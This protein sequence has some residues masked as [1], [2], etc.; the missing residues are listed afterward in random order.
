MDKEIKIQWEIPKSWIDVKLEDISF[1]IQGQSPPSS[2]YNSERIGLPFF[3][4]KA[5]FTDLHPKVKVWCKEPTKIA[6]PNDILLSVRA[7]VGTTNIANLK[8]GIGRGLSAIRYQYAHKFVFYYLRLIERELDK[9]GT[10]TTFK[11]IS[12]DVVRNTH[13]PLPPLPEQNRIVEKL[14][15]LLSELE[16]GKEQL[17]LALG[18]LKVYRQAVLKWAFEG[19][20][21]R[22]N[23][24]LNGLI[25]DSDW[26][27]LP[28][29]ISGTHNLLKI[30][31]SRKDELPEDWEWVKIEELLV[32]PKKGMTTGPF[33]TALKKEEHK[34]SG[35]PVL[36]IE[37]IGEGKFRMPN[38]IFVSKNKALELKAFSVLTNDII[39]SRSGTVGEICSV[40]EKMENAL[41]ST[42]LIRVRLNQNKISSKYFVYLFQGGTVREQ[43]RELCKGSTRAFLNQTILK[44]LYFPFCS[45]INQHIIVS[46]IES[47]FSI[48]DK[49]EETIIQALQQ[50]ETLKQSLLQKAFEGKLVP[51]DPNDEPASVLLERIKREREAIEKT[52]RQGAKRVRI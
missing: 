1:V 52:A 24:I 36:G 32:H 20:L 13:I 39:I 48:C 40:P 9:R 28:N 7:P 18:Q 43:V 49:I 38:K 42:N 11:A 29:R 2:T 27:T 14:D 34:E 26:D 45:L 23:R 15:E 5:E 10:G 31:N 41:I 50:A 47:R 44:S 17:Q 51:Q 12:G 19:R 16:K 33:G 25:D 3:Q 46:E 22:Q 4:G 21:T 37:N 6:E 35:I 30:E 8:C